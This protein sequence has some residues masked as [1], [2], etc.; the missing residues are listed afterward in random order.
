MDISTIM[1]LVFALFAIVLG[2]G[3][4]LGKMIDIP[5]FFI[6]VV[7]SLGATFIAHPSSTSFKIF[8]IILQSFKNPK[9]DNIEALRTL[10]SFSEKARR[11]GMISLEEDLPSV[12]SD[13]LRDGLRAA[14]DGTDPEEI[15]KILEIKM[16]MYEE[17]QEEKISVLDTWGTMAPAFGIS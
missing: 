1:G 2:V 6:T 12:E 5:S 17:E 9:I 7:G 16:D 14:V 4:E 3:T 10:Y 13:F 8:N 11:E 15:R